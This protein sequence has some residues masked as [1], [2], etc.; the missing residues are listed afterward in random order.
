MAIIESADDAS[1]TCIYRVTVIVVDR[2]GGSDATGVNIQITDTIEAPSTPARP[3]V[4]AKEKSSTSLVV[5]WSAPANPGPPIY[6]LRRAVPQGQRPILGRQLPAN[7]GRKQLPRPNR[8]SVTIT[9]LDDDTAYEVRVKAKNSERDSAWSATGTGRTNRANHEPI[10]DDR[11][12]TGTGAMRNND[13]TVWR[14]IDEN[15]R[16]GQVVGRVFADDEDNDSLT[17]KLVAPTDSEAA[18]A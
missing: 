1:T 7:S 15:P 6:R 3:T 17:Y 2:A 12:G 8:Y 5:T 9:M 4:R 11:P 10:F 18:R 14:T 13:F 16:A